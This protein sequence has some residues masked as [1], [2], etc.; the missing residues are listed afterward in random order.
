M[1]SEGSAHQVTSSTQV[2]PLLVLNSYESRFLKDHL[3]LAE[4]KMASETGLH[5]GLNLML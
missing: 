5:P 3:V 4:S 2:R 1:L